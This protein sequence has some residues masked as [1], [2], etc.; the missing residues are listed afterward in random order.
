LDQVDEKIVEI[1]EKLEE[2]IVLLSQTP[3]NGEVARYFKQ[4]FDHAIKKANKDHAHPHH[5]QHEEAEVLQGDSAPNNN[6]LKRYLQARH[7]SNIIFIVIDIIMIVIGVGMIILPAT[8]L[9]TMFT[10][11]YFS[12]NDGITLVDLISLLII[13]AGIYFLIREIYPNPNPGNKNNGSFNRQL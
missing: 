12:R 10:I 4:Q 2:L 1:D 7:I 6:R 9:F 8:P 3:I 5:E 13:L 11:H